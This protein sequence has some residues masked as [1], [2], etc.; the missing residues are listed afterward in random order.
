[1]DIKKGPT[2]KAVQYM[3]GEILYGGRVTD[4]LDKILLNTY[5]STMMGDHMLK[6][7]FKFKGE[8]IAPQCKTGL[9]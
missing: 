9:S 1:M 7:E 6:P 4:D 2:W 8:Y 3:F 5:C